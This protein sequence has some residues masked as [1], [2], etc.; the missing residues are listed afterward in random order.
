MAI[1]HPP[2]CC[3]EITSISDK[4][5]WSEFPALPSVWLCILGCQW[6]SLLEA[7]PLGQ[8]LELQAPGAVRE[9]DF[10][11]R[12]LK[13]T[14]NTCKRWV[15]EARKVRRSLITSLDGQSPSFVLICFPPRA[16]NLSGTSF[17]CRWGSLIWINS[18]ALLWALFCFVSLLWTMQTFLL[19][20]S[21]SGEIL[22][23][24]VQLARKTKSVWIP[25]PVRRHLPL[26]PKYHISHDLVVPVHLTPLGV[27]LLSSDLRTLCNN[28]YLLEILSPTHPIQCTS[29]LAQA[30]IE[31][32]STVQGHSEDQR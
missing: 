30:T 24:S 5:L 1:M 20:C 31:I 28:S 2:E 3:L 23:T 7:S 11:R 15:W 13:K 8:P 26:K 21:V 29:F 19:S 6:A 4:S 17:I 18:T 32:I 9:Q 12:N 16:S 14:K 25:A 27:S 10:W 22:W